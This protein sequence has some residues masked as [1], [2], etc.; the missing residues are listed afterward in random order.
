[1]DKLNKKFSALHG[2]TSGLNS[3]AFLALAGLGLAVSM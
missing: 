3:I 1:M 2:L